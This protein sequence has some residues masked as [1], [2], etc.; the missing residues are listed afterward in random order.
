MTECAQQLAAANGIGQIVVAAVF[1]V[2]QHQRTAVVQRVQ[3]A[4]VQRSRLI[5]AVAVAF[6]QFFQAGARQATQLLL[7]AQLH[8][9]N[10]AV[11][12]H[13][14]GSRAG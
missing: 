4:L 11:L 14:R 5:E 10:G 9:Q 2:E 12:R 3:F 8:G 13:V 7:G 1:G 6:E